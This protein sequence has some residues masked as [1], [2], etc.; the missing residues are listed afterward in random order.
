MLQ[1][2]IAKQRAP[3]IY[4][5]AICELDD[6]ENIAVVRCLNCRNYGMRSALC[7]HHYNTHE[8]YCHQ[9][10]NKNGKLVVKSKLSLIRCCPHQLVRQP[11]ANTI[12]IQLIN[13]FGSE[14]VYVEECEQHS[15]PISLIR[16]GFFLSYLDKFGNSPRIVLITDFDVVDV[17]FCCQLLEDAVLLNIA[18][19]S[20]QAIGNVLNNMFYDVEIM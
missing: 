11:T 7:D 6:C 3:D 20:L 12:Q 1:H 4:D 19:L 9:L 5:G 8:A 15:V 2:F 10:V 13:K 17:A 14:K 16:A 18:G